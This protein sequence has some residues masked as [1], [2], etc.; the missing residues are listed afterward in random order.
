MK[1]RWLR[2]PGENSPTWLGRGQAVMASLDFAGFF[3]S[4][5]TCSAR[6]QE[7]GIRKPAPFKMQVRRCIYTTDQDLL[8]LN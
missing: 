7:G 3:P 1:L 4:E 5:E 8:D 6:R 2:R